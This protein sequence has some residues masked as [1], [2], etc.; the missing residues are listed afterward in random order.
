MTGAFSLMRRSIMLLALGG[1]AITVHAEV[2]APALTFTSIDGQKLRLSE[3]RGKVVLVTFW[4]TTCAICLVEQPELV[5]TYRRY[6]PRGLE[7]VAVA[8]PYDRL[9]LIRQ[10]IAKYPMPFPVVWDKDG[11]IGRQFRDI[12]GTPTTFIVDKKG[13]LVSK[14]VGAIDFA[15]LRSFLDAT[16]RG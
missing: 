14:T 11:D 4:A 13:H 16:L 3:L 12:P 7:V 9:D 5:Q 15:K 1:A 10:H 8:M 6:R 2:V